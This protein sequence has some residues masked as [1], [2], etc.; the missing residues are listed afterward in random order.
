MTFNRMAMFSSACGDWE[1]P[2][3]LFN[4]LNKE[5]GFTLDACATA[6]TAKCA[7]F[8]TLADNGLGCPWPGTV[9]VNPPYGSGITAWIAKGYSEARVWGHTVVMLLP[10]RT[11]TAW[12]HEYVLRAD[13]IRFIRGRLK[14]SGWHTSAPFPSMVVV[15]RGKKP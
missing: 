4:E 15:F 13:E 7:E 3:G 11:D 2:Q 5:F 10:S 9:F 6:E 1:T 14:F 8:Y 12:F